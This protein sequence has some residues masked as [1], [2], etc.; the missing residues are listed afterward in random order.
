M[1]GMKSWRQNK[2]S[3]EKPLLSVS[4]GK[5]VCFAVFNQLRISLSSNFQSPYR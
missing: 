5:F 2:K 1:L 4:R 3:I